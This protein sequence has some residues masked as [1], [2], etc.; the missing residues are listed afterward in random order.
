M[1]QTINIYTNAIKVCFDEKSISI[2]KDTKNNGMTI[3]FKRPVDEGET[4][5]ELTCYS[6]IQDGFR[7]TILSTSKEA[8]L[9]L[10]VAI[11]EYLKTIEK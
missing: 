1:E 9:S 5:D 11:D 10:K 6:S 2:T 7:T 8:L 3:F 4:L